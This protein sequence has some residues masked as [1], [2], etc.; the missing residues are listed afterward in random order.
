MLVLTLLAFDTFNPGEEGYVTDQGVFKLSAEQVRPG[1]FKVRAIEFV[2]AGKHGKFV[3]I[4]PEP[5]AKRSDGSS[6]PGQNRNKTPFRQTLRGAEDRRHTFDCSVL[7]R[8][9]AGA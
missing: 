3:E 9:S 1:W 8:R 6:W 4:D 5:E 2:A 7:D